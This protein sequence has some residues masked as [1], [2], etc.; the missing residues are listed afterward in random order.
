MCRVALDMLEDAGYRRRSTTGYYH[1]ERVG[2]YCRFLDYYWRTEPMIGFG[3]GSKSVV[4]NRCWTN[5]R[6]MTDYIKRLNNNETVLD[7]ATHMTK[8]QEM[9]RIMI[10]GLKVCEV[11]KKEHFYDRFGVEMETVFPDEIKSLVEQGLITNDSNKIALTK[12]GQVYSSNVFEKFYTEDDL[13]EPEEGE[14]QFGISD[15]VLR[16]TPQQIAVQ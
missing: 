13:R 8:R 11:H 4:G 9:L 16:E 14:V 2:R 10:R 1:P 5:V 15:L 3:V 12:E 7:F 6:S